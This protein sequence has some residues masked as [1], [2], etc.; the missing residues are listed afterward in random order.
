MNADFVDRARSGASSFEAVWSDTCI[1][2]LRLLIHSCWK[3]LRGEV[4]PYPSLFYLAGANANTIHRSST[5]IGEGEARMNMDTMVR[6]IGLYKIPRHDRYARSSAAEVLLKEAREM[7]HELDGRNEHRR[8][9][10]R[11]RSLCSQ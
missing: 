7:M 3:M 6:W 4:I 9:H 10:L 8:I 5:S 11:M 2:L 1:C